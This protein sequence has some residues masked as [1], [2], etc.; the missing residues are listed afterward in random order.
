MIVR[1]G[2]QV[3]VPPPEGFTGVLGYA[4]PTHGQNIKL[5]E[6]NGLL[7][8]IV[9]PNGVLAGWDTTANAT[10]GE[11][12]Q[13]LWNLLGQAPSGRL[14]HTPVQPCAALELGLRLDAS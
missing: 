6:S 10:R 2:S 14:E 4:D 8:G 9:G 3:L 11:V 5:A 12:A 1:A 7:D 13:M